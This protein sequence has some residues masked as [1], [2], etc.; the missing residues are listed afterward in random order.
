MSAL[1]CKQSRQR[2]HEGSIQGSHLQLQHIAQKGTDLELAE[3]T[4][5]CSSDDG[6]IRRVHVSLRL[7][8]FGLS[9]NIM[10][11]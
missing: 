11:S 6:H 4:S 2:N 5:T 1:G 9:E 8:F 7:L 10:G 3:Q